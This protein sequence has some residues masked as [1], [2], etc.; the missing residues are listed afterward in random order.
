MLSAV[1]SRRHCCRQSKFEILQN[2]DMDPDVQRNRIAWE[3]A[4]QAI[5]F[6][7][8]SGS[9]SMFWSISNFDWRQ[10]CRRETT[11]DNIQQDPVSLNGRH[12][13]RSVH[14]DEALDLTSRLAAA[15]EGSR[16]D[17]SDLGRRA[18]RPQ[19]ALPPF[20][21]G[22][23]LHGAESAG[24]AI[25][26]ATPG[27]P[28]RRFPRRLNQPAMHVSATPNQSVWRRSGRGWLLSDGQWLRDRSVPDLRQG[29]QTPSV[30]TTTG[31][32]ATQV[33]TLAAP[34]AIT[35]EGSATGRTACRGPRSVGR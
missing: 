4:S 27:A 24:L 33:V 7:C 13:G 8:T 17:L 2:M 25:Q 31:R 30:V 32:L 11:A 18:R 22:S 12:P 23:G 6:R 1:V 14:G 10:Q 9:M 15:A 35:S 29:G 28:A 19:A 34:L 26:A 20:A 21:T 5:R 16:V 3:A